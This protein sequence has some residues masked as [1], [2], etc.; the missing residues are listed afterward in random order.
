MIFKNMIGVIV[1]RVLPVPVPGPNFGSGSKAYGS[2][3]VPGRFQVS[4]PLL[5]F[6]FRFLIGGS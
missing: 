2:G 5:N 4:V 6:R 1:I 3:A